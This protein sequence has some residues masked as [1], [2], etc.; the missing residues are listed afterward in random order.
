MHFCGLSILKK[1]PF[2]LHNAKC[3]TCPFEGDCDGGAI[4]SK[5]NH[6][7]L[8][9]KFGKV[10]FYSCPP[11]YCCSSLKTCASYNTCTEYRAGTLCGNCKEGHVLSLFSH[12]QCIDKSCCDYPWVVW[13]GYIFAV[14]VLCLFFLYNEDVW[15]FF[16]SP[17][18][19]DDNRHIGESLGEVF[20]NDTQI[21]LLTPKPPDDSSAKQLTG[22]IKITFFFYQSASII[23]IL[24]SAK[25]F[26]NMPNILSFLVSFFDIRLELTGDVLKVCPPVYI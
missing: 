11:L 18:A 3:Y 5:S 24:A 2:F 6:W 25:T 21:P 17:R 20:E 26:Y 19:Q 14:T 9:D 1:T 16:K 7:G 15:R 22:V 8:T 10:T 13:L 4:R 23:R 12:N